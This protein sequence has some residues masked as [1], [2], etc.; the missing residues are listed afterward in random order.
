METFSASL[1]LCAGNSPVPGE[2]PTQRP[3]TRS[4]DVYFDLRPNKGLSKQWRGWW[5]EMQSC[6]LWRH[7][8]AMTYFNMATEIS[9]RVSMEKSREHL[10]GCWGEPQSAKMAYKR[11][12]HVIIIVVDDL[13]PNRRHAIS[14]HQV[15]LPV[16]LH[17]IHHRQPKWSRPHL[18]SYR[19]NLN[20]LSI[21]IFIGRKWMGI[22]IYVLSLLVMLI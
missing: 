4:F 21:L 3:V 9:L 1:A 13:T 6:S 12:A 5:F 19:F 8:N 10:H 17:I 7:F 11:L 14:N 16:T 20:S 15:D 18:S 2:F 22:I